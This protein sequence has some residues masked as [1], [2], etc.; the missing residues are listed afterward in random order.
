MRK[1]YD[2][3]KLCK[4]KKFL[5]FADL[6][7][8]CNREKAGLKIKEEAIEKKLVASKFKKESDKKEAEEIKEKEIIEEKKSETTDD[9]KAK[10]EV[11]KKE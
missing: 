4:S 3:C 11:E 10:G 7:R 2:E 6:C 9:D 1:K 5:N 8:K